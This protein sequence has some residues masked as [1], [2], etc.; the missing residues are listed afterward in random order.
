MIT[1]GHLNS[2]PTAER[3]NLELLIVSYS[4]EMIMKHVWLTQ[5]SLYRISNMWNYFHNNFW[6]HYIFHILPKW[7]VYLYLKIQLTI[8]I[9][10][11]NISISLITK[12]NLT[13]SPCSN[14]PIFPYMSYV[15]LSFTLVLPYYEFVRSTWLGRGIHKVSFFLWKSLQPKQLGE[16]GLK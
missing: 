9:S 11:L 1:H 10:F 5:I 2:L 15:K 8:S 7:N 6:K 14:S 16:S 4:Y 3:Q 13:I 12:W